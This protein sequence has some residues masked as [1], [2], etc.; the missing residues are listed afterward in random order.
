MRR[1]NVSRPL[2]AFAALAVVASGLTLAA[3]GDDDDD[4]GNL[5]TVT[6][7]LNWTP[8]T[9]H[10]GIYLAVEKG[11][12][13]DAGL[14]VKIVEPAAGGVEQVI[15]TGKAEFGISVQEAVV[16]AR[17]E[18][19]P[20]VSIA[21]I[22]QHNDS[23]LMALAK[24]GIKR[25]KDLEGKTY[26]GFGGPLET[27]IVSRLV[28]CDGGDPKKVKFAEVGN[29]DYLVGMEQGQYDFVW[30]FE[31][32]DVL[33]ARDVEGK[34]VST[35]LFKDYLKCIPDWYTP[36]FITS[37]G[38]AKKSPETVKK[39]MEATAKG[40]DLAGKD[41]AAAAAALLKASPESD[42]KLVEASAKYHVGKY[43]DSGRA[44][45]AQ[46]RATWDAFVKFLKE[47][48]LLEKEIDVTAA[49]TNDYLP[50]K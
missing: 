28:A 9:Q 39:F 7:M 6:L 35:V 5:E 45:G 36:V 29:V 27:E 18:G 2:L 43:V 34:A 24:S 11:Y 41:G 23:S 33:R 38:F 1:P 22:L 49:F 26:G 31:G 47:A 42:K 32:W 37:E 14:D 17:A 48:K 44:W 16:P 19:V 10:S 15:A 21:A 40:Y 4:G 46:D 13:K 12:Y 20:I 25:P 50:K 30:V 8:N 3:C